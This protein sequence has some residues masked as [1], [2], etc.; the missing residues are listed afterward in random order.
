M[1][2]H[3][4]LGMEVQ[5]FFFTFSTSEWLELVELEHLNC[6]RPLVPLQVALGPLLLHVA[7]PHGLSRKEARILMWWFRAPKGEKVEAARPS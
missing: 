3:G 4:V 5:G 6:L 1:V 2:P 7:S